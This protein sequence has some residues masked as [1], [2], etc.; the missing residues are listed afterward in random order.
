MPKS[1]ELLKKV[2]GVV[3]GVIGMLILWLVCFS[4]T[5]LNVKNPIFIL[6]LAL[7]V[8]VVWFDG[9]LTSKRNEDEW[10]EK[11]RHVSKVVLKV[12]LFLVVGLIV[13][14]FCGLLV[15]GCMLGVVMLI[16]TAVFVFIVA[17]AVFNG[18]FDHPV[19]DFLVGLAIIAVIFFLGG[20]IFGT[21]ELRAKEYVAILRLNEESGTMDDIPSDA[22]YMVLGVN[23]VTD[24]ADLKYAELERKGA[25]YA[26]S[27]CLRKTRW[28]FPTKQFENP[29]F[30]TDEKENL[31]FIVSVYDYK[32]GLYGCKDIVGVIIANPIKGEWE[33]HY[34]DLD[35]I[36]EWVDV[37]FDG[38]LICRQYNYCGKYSK[39]FLNSL[40]F[41]AQDGCMEVADIGDV[42]YGYFTLAGDV[43]AYAGVSPI[44][45]PNK[46]NLLGFIIGNERTG[47]VK[48]IPFPSIT[49]NAAMDAA[50]DAEDVKDKGY[51]A[52]FP[53]IT[54]LIG[55]ADTYNVYVGIL[56]DS[57]GTSRMYYVVNMEQESD[58]AIADTCA[59]A[60]A[61]YLL[62][63]GE[64]LSII[65][66]N[67]AGSYHEKTVAIRKVVYPGDGNIY[68]VTGDDDYYVAKFREEYILLNEGDIV[69]I[70]VNGDGRRFYGCY[71]NVS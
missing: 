54:K 61:A 39:G 59:D 21:V 29:H 36:P 60:V 38:D 11:R 52:S 69:T 68:I 46:S 24:K 12:L 17:Y 13:S 34:Y 66:E 45:E 62:M 65:R 6:K 63:K 58:L 43:W 26:T 22:D 47:E 44:K 30:E 49:V 8:W 18:Y 16:I 40:P 27:E 14:W 70:V 23:P 20:H 57:N 67:G 48:F 71:P 25:V 56:K 35:N 9:Y 55:D 3:L 32:V 37:V 5:A 64:P 53:S 4:S 41:C 2:V 42:D 50:E 33:S 28:D 7:T 31:W 15:T 51:Y 19:R 1:K 10:P